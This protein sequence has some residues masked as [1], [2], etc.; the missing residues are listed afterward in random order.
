MR[1]R[2]VGIE[3]DEMTISHREVRRHPIWRRAVHV[4]REVAGPGES[5]I[6]RGRVAAVTVLAAVVLA[7]VIVVAAG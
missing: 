4:R 7:V 2:M 5:V 1:A 3:A 6:P